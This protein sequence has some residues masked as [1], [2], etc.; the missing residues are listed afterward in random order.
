MGQCYTT[1]LKLRYKDEEGA[2]KALQKFLTRNDENALEEVHRDTGLDLDTMDGLLRHFYSNWEY[3][4]KWTET[5]DP[6]V[7]CGDFNA[8]YCW[9][10]IM[11]EAFEAMAPYLEDGSSLK[12]YPD[13][14]YDLQVVKN[15]KAVQIH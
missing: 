14:S 5:T 6:D 13:S 8:N 12:I 11:M 2:K 1:Y 10:S 3:G 4:H 9:E 7:L 15:G